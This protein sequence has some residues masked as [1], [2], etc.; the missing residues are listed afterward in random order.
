MATRTEVNP[1]PGVF[2]CPDCGSEFD[3]H[4]ALTSH[5]NKRHGSEDGYSWDRQ[6]FLTDYVELTCEQCGETYECHPNNSECSR[7]CSASCQST[8]K[9]ENDRYASGEDHW[10]WGGGDE[11]QK[12]LERDDYQCQRCGCDVETGNRMSQQNA[13]IHHII[14]RAAGGPD[15]LEN[16]VTLCR[17]CHKKAHRAMKDIGERAPGVLEELRDVVC[18]EE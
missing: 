16:Y 8:W 7:F 2:Q 4:R 13:E 15:A 12:A 17:R 5:Y 18:E 10:N 3:S 1:E 14:P 11:R 6:E 9:S